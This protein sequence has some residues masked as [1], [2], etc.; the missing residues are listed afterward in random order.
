MKYVHDKDTYNHLLVSR[1]FNELSN[2]DFKSKLEY[3]FQISAR[4]FSE[5]TWVM[6]L[7]CHMLYDTTYFIKHYNFISDQCVYCCQ[8][9][10]EGAN[11]SEVRHDFHQMAL[12]QGQNKILGLYEV[13]PIGS[14]ADASTAHA[15][16]FLKKKKCDI[17]EDITKLS[18]LESVTSDTIR[19]CH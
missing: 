15:G 6:C 19:N 11:T 7:G 16:G 12:F 4:N 3:Y 18:Q 13:H 5:G 10:T 17:I 9:V 1:K 2:I 8:Q 14:H